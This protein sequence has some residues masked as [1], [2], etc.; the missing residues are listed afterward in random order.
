MRKSVIRIT[1]VQ[2]F[3][4]ETGRYVGTVEHE[5]AGWVAKDR[6]CTRRGIWSSPR[7]AADVLVAHYFPPPPAGVVP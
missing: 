5:G 4:Q 6:D 7:Q 1:A 2:V 3:A